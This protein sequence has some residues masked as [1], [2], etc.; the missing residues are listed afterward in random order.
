M[1][2]KSQCST[3]EKFSLFL[4]SSHLDMELRPNLILKVYS[5]CLSHN[6]GWLGLSS[7]ELVRLQIS[8]FQIKGDYKTSA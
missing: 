2:L 7:C 4:G 1:M 8:H 5:L 6:T 3:T